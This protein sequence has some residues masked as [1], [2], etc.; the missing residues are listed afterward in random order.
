MGTC[1]SDG[2]HLRHVNVAHSFPGSILH[3]ERIWTIL[4][5]IDLAESERCRAAG[6][7]HCGHR[8]RGATY[9]R[10][11][12]GLAA[13]LCA[14]VRRLS[15]CCVECRRRTTPPSVCF[16]GRRFRVGCVFVGLSVQLLGRSAP[17]ETA[18]RLLG[19]PASTLRRLLAAVVSRRVPGD[20]SVA[21][22]A[23]RTGG[24]PG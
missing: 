21:L 17:V 8:L 11:P 18:S 5:E 14:G 2:D 4:R 7:R 15:F 13:S 16:F 23:G 1:L 19:V 3:D 12:H 24:G 9:P 22:E 20:A 6:C 10:K